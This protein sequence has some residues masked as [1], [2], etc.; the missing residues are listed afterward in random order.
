MDMFSPET[1]GKTER[2]SRPRMQT[3]HYVSVLFGDGT[4]DFLDVKGNLSPRRSDALEY[5]DIAEA[6]FDCDILTARDL[7][8]S[9][10]TFQRYFQ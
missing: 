7:D 6:E 10:E 1:I 2:F 9:V 4:V 5:D 3:F 8:A